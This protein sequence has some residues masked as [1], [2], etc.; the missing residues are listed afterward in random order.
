MKSRNKYT[1]RCV[2]R[3]C[4]WKITATNVRVRPARTRACRCFASGYEL[5]LVMKSSISR[6]W[7][8]VRPPTLWYGIPFC[9]LHR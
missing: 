3:L 6:R 7:K 8:N 4:M 5:L 2:P 9:A 1:S